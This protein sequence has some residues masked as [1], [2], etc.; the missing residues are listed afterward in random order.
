MN[1][2]RP[3]APQPQQTGLGALT[4]TNV[5]GAAAGGAITGGLLGFG[6]AYVAKKDMRKGAL[7]GVGIGAALGLI[8]ALSTQ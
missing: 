8:G 5:V 6:I 3:L 2:Q 1:D 4:S 7:Y